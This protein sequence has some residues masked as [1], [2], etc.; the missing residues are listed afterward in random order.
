MQYV[1]HQTA[2][3]Y[4]EVLGQVFRVYN[5][6]GFQITTVQFDNEFCPLIKPLADYFNVVMNFA[7]AQEHV[8]EAECNNRIIKE[9]VRAT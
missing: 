3:V 1:K 2:G 6:G 5:T 9:C 4:G 7:N 8:P